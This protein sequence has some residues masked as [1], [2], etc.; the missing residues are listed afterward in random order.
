MIPGNLDWFSADGG[1]VMDGLPDGSTD[2]SDDGWMESSFP[3]FSYFVKFCTGIHVSIFTM[4]LADGWMDRTD[5]GHTDGQMD[6]QVA[7]GL[8]WLTDESCN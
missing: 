1:E 2:K 3:G 4:N 5:H 6:F 8:G 7:S